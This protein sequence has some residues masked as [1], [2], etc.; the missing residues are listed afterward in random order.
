MSRSQH[1]PLTSETHLPAR[2]GSGAHIRPTLRTPLSTLSHNPSPFHACGSLP[3]PRAPSLTP[4]RARGAPSPPRRRPGL[5][6]VPAR[7]AGAREPRPRAATRSCPLGAGQ[8]PEKARG[9]LGALG[10]RGEGRSGAGRGGGARSLTL[11]C[12]H[13]RT[14]SHTDT[15]GVRCRRPPLLLLPPPP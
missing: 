2:P 9:A 4:T 11:G 3:L 7:G 12:A 8:K 10:A 1:S 15:R 14:N 6:A 13:A 5:Y